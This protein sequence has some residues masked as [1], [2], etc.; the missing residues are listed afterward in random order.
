MNIRKSILSIAF[1]MGAAIT[2]T[3]AEGMWIP[4]F[5]KKLNETE[6]KSLGMKIDADDIYSVNHSSLKDAV[7]LFGGGCTGE[8]V[9][10]EGLLLTNHHCGYSVIAAHS[11]MENNIL[12][13]GFWAKDKSEELI[14]PSLSVTFIKRIEE[15]TE[16]ALSGVTDDMDIAAR[17]EKINQN[18]RAIRDTARREEWQNIEIKPFFKD[19]RYFMFIRETYSDVRL[20]GCPP[21]SVG[22]YGS[23]T[24]NWVWPR[25]TGDFSVFRIYADKNN[26]PAAP[27]ADNV[28]YRPDHFFP[29]SLNGVKEGDFTL[30]FGFPG[31][32]D[33]Y[34]PA[35]AL[36]QT[37]NHRN[38]VK[39]G[40]RDIALKVWGEEMRANDTTKLLY[41]NR[42]SSVANAWKKWQ[43][44]SL[45]LNRTKGFDKKKR[46]EADFLSTEV[47]KRPENT[48]LLNDLYSQYE[49][50]LPYGIAY[51]ITS[52][53]SSLSDAYKL[54]SALSRL[55]SSKDLNIVERY[56]KTA[57]SLLDSRTLPIDRRA[58]VLLADFWKK[59]IPSQFVPED[60]SAIYKECGEDWNKVAE[61]IYSD[62]LFTKEGIENWYKKDAET[63][64]KELAESPLGVFYSSINNMMTEKV[65]PVYNEA[66]N[67]IAFLMKRYM[68]AQMEAFPGKAFFPDANLTLRASYGQVKGM[69]A[70]DGIYYIPQTYLDGV[71]E[72]YIPGDFE[73]DLPAKVLELYQSKDYGRYA[74]GEGRMPVCFIATNHTTGGNSGSPAINAYGQLIGLNFDRLWEGTM[75]DLNYDASICRNIM[76]DIRYVLWLIDKVGGAGYLLDEM[77][78]IQGDVEKEKTANK[79]S[80]RK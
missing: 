15:V 32:T 76:V 12:Q 10:A 79:K 30:V 71:I 68:A 21:V 58:F 77:T 39:V 24:D 41:A 44:E 75:S 50:L 27:S 4:L 7:V 3:A 48:Q 6:M 20:V 72:K 28:P 31:R 73:Y 35:P 61:K 17:N 42:Y 78:I 66:N 2:L 18:L 45:G 8:V 16:A 62:A 56:K 59:N 29:I 13:N 9:S 60:V 36:E 37:A 23:E 65:L 63:R 5:L 43:G 33:E 54:Y 47:G 11:T 14:N 40:M 26:R 67:Q 64:K 34:L 46:Y 22:K 19:N 80:K 57:L 69:Q 38:P 55:L 53:F 49:K 70:R 51:D 52:E 1:F 74:D 25:H